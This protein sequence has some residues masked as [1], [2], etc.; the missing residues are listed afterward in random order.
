MKYWW[1]TQTDT[2]AFVIK[3][4]TLWSCPQPNGVEPLP[5]LQIQ[6]MRPGDLVF[7]YDSPW[8]RAVSVVTQK[9]QPAPRPIG[10]YG[11]EEGWL[12]RVKPQIT[13]L[14]IRLERVAELITHGRLG[15]LTYQGALAPKYISRLTDDEGRRLLH[16]VQVPPPP[17]LE[18][19]DSFLGRPETTWDEQ[20]TEAQGLAMIR[21]EQ[22]HLRQHLL[23]G[24]SAAP[25]AI[26]GMESPARLLIAGHI[27]P[28]YLCTEAERTDFDAAAMLVCALGCDALFEWGYIVVDASGQ[29]CR[30][31]P[32]ETTA[33][34][35]AVNRLIGRP[36]AAYRAAT[37]INFEAHRLMLEQDV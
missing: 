30:G 27:K 18:D 15:P 37:A 33:L 8:L 32:A 10:Y 1:A 31:R 6:H 17:S 11:E 12:V 14:T 22:A 25:C 34:E 19:P 26:C 28:R 16:E 3:E 9:W 24:R 2:Y 23:Q 4:G 5:R 29:I 7:H 36:C 35:T 21:R 13:G 20:G